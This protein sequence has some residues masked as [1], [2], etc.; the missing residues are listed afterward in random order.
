MASS[1]SPL[2]IPLR[3]AI[4][5]FA[6]ALG[7][8]GTSVRRAPAPPG[9]GQFVEP[10]TSTSERRSSNMHTMTPVIP[11]PNL[12]VEAN[13]SVLSR[14]LWVHDVGELHI[15]EETLITTTV[16]VAGRQIE[17]APDEFALLMQLAPRPY[18]VISNEDLYKRLGMDW[19]DEPLPPGRL[20]NLAS[21]SQPTGRA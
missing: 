3:V 20:V 16:H 6:E 7:R 5:R 18:E 11:T 15:E 21:R 2:G 14:N 9:K 8:A 17:L 19:Y 4:V 10:L 12:W 1:S 13:G